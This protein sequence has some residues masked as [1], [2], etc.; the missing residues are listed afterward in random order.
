MNRHRIWR[1]PLA[2]GTAVVLAH[3][4]ALFVLAGC[5]SS[6]VTLS[7]GRG[8][9]TDRL[10]RPD[11]IIVHDFAATRADLP[12]DMTRPTTRELQEGSQIPEQIAAGREFGALVAQELV[13]HIQKMGLTAERATNST[14]ANIGDVAIVGEV[15][16]VEEG[17]RGTR[18]MLGFGAGSSELILEINGYAHTRWGPQWLGARQV[19][20]SGGKTPGLAVP[21]LAR[22]PA[23][24]VANTA[25]KTKGERGSETL[26]S[27]AQRAVAT[28]AE[29]LA[30]AFRKNGWI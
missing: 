13:V 8:A 6:E 27:A 18:V 7:E 2:S 20:T 16:S 4:V 17:S 1:E 23:G 3:A 24:L 14:T 12:E 9:Q 19:Q 30:A 25:I 5:A 15:L 29:E 22:S 28:I 26:T 10:D 11:R 21:I